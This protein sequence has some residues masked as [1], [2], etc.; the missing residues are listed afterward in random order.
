MSTDTARRPRIRYL[1]LKS[2][3]EDHD[4]QAR[5]HTRPEYAREFSEAMLNGATFPPITVF[6]DGKHY[7]IVDGFHRLSAHKQASRVEPAFRQ[8]RAEI[9]E[10]SKRDAIL[11]AAGTNKEWSI[12]RTPEDIKRAISFILDDE[13]GF[14]WSD[15]RIAKHIGV[16]PTTVGRT[17]QEYCKNKGLE[18]PSVFTRSDDHQ[19]VRPKR[20]PTR[21]TPV[22]RPQEQEP[23]P[24]H[25]PQAQGP[26]HPQQP[27]CPSDNHRQPRTASEAA[28]QLGRLGF[29][30]RGYRDPIN[31]PGIRGF[32]GHGC[33][34][35]VADLTSDSEIHHEIGNIIMFSSLMEEKEFVKDGSRMVLICHMEDGPQPAISLA[36]KLGIE[37][38]TLEEFAETL[39]P[40]ESKQ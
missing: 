28:Q 12:K 9:H 13:D 16:N 22:S 18:V 34:Y 26:K 3:T 38:L 32:Y 27:Y 30:F 17:R 6:Y 31:Y 33:V 14:H 21:P 15:S 23:N 7:Y 35:E 5:V 39:N 8:I 29:T 25:P 2:I 40:G 36:S 1:D 4:C 11:H 20:K 19:F 10:G 24:V 37:F